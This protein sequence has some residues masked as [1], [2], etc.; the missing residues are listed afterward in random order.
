MDL[1]YLLSSTFGEFRIGLCMFL[2][3]IKKWILELKSMRILTVNML[4]IL[5]MRENRST[6]TQ[7][8]MLQRQIQLYGREK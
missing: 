3:R 4:T 8:M 7:K 1:D 6:E 5:Y 2:V